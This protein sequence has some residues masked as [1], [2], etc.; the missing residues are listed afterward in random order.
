MDPCGCPKNKFKWL[1]IMYPSV[2]VGQEIHVF[3][4]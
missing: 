3:D 1:K 4:N 2:K